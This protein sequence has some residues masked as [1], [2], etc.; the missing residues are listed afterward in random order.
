MY[1]FMCRV[2]IDIAAADTS[3]LIDAVFYLSARLCVLL[4][5]EWKKKF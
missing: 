4:E 3:V 5:N 1:K 2:Y